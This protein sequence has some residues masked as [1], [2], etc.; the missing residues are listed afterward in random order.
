MSTKKVIKLQVR[1]LDHGSKQRMMKTSNRAQTC[2][3][4]NSMLTVLPPKKKRKREK[5]KKKEE[6]EEERGRGRKDKSLGHSLS[7]SKSLRTGRSSSFSQKFPSILLSLR[8][9]GRLFY[10]VGAALENAPT[11]KDALFSQ[12]QQ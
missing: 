11:P 3:C 7:K 4:S 5:K 6:K 10:S 2:P 1:C 12:Q 9:T 8:V